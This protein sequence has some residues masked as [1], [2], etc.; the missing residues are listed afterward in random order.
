M[1]SYYALIT[2]NMKKLTDKVK[3]LLQDYHTDTYLQIYHK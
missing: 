2:N 3:L 1:C